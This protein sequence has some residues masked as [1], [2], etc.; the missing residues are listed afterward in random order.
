MISRGKVLI[1]TLAL[2]ALVACA[3][4]AA[5]ASASEL[6][7][8]TC[9]KAAGGVGPYNTSQCAT[10]GVSGEF[11]TKALPLN[12]ETEVTGA[13]TEIEPM[14]RATLGG[15][16]VTVQCSKTEGINVKITNRE[17]AA[18]KH[19]AEYTSASTVFTGCKAVLKANEARNCL[20]EGSAMGTI[21][22]TALKGLTTGVEHRV[23]IAP[24]EG[25]LFT[26]FTIL[27][28][29]KGGIECP[30]SSDVAVEVKGL[31]EGEANTNNHAHVT[32][33]EANNGT[34][35][36]VNGGTA[37]LLDTIGG[38]MKGT[39]TVIGVQTFT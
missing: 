33:T 9:V 29:A 14:L 19:E 24:A 27:N 36:K 12:T 21:S 39:T 6:T 37:S 35:L 15:S 1:S 26:K 11:E 17:T 22:T 5:G 7:A 38:V 23:K 30:F 10:P 16:A 13:A 25:E 32:F 18:G 4:A 31:V 34:A 8:A 2:C 20:V 3:F 28:K